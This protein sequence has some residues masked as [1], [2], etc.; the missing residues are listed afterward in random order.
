V[1]ATYAMACSYWSLGALGYYVWETFGS[2]YKEDKYSITAL[3]LN[4]VSSI[5]LFV[6]SYACFAI[7]AVIRRKDFVQDAFQKFEGKWILE[8]MRASIN[9]GLSSIALQDMMV[10]DQNIK[11]N[12]I[13]R[14]Q[15]PSAHN[16]TRIS[17]KESTKSDDVFSD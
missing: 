12:K 1:M 15:R 3:C 4:L 5:C 17:H 10:P 11:K 13:L 6:M 8:T 14:Q 2:T 9:V 16:Q 7:Q